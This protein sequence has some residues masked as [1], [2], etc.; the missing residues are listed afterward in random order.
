MA[1]C[2][3]VGWRLRE[4]GDAILGEEWGMIPFRE[5]LIL[6]TGK[7]VD[8]LLKKWDTNPS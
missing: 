6:Q 5:I 7:G 3:A 4:S 2:A 1:H 8:P